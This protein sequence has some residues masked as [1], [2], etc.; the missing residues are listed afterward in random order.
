M[1]PI[2]ELDD[3]ITK[4][5][6]SVTNPTAFSHVMEILCEMAEQ[7][8]NLKPINLGEKITKQYVSRYEKV[9][10]QHISKQLKLIQKMGFLTENDLNTLDKKIARGCYDDRMT[11]EVRYEVFRRLYQHSKLFRDLARDLMSQ[12]YTISEIHNQLANIHGLN[13]T[14]RQ[15]FSEWINVLKVVENFCGKAELAHWVEKRTLEQVTTKEMYALLESLVKE[16][17]ENR[18]V[19]YDTFKEEL[20][21]YL[22]FGTLSNVSLDKLIKSID[23]KRIISI[24]Q[25]K[26]Y[27]M[28]VH[29]NPQGNFKKDLK[30]I[31]LI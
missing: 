5:L 1:S 25:G 15:K 24:H 30:L 23:S 16:Y 27:R 17:S 12:K 8:K 13:A 28:F 29:I 18:Y 21:D 20:T 11:E 19:K 9:G 7:G 26:D 6:L 3:I 22:T 2:I 10:L 31:D 14:A 4:H